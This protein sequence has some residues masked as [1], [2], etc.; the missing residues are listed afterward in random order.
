LPAIAGT[1]NAPARIAPRRAV[2]V[3]ARIIPV[4][5]TVRKIPVIIHSPARVLPGVIRMSAGVSYEG[6][7]GGKN[8]G[9][10][11]DQ[12]SSYQI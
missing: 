9:E 10:F 11:F 4:A 1:K 5:G 7:D 6:Y 3:R 8:T 12:V 2:A